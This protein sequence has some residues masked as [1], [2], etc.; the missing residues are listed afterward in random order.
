MELPCN[1][2][3]ENRA[4]TKRQIVKAEKSKP[5]S[6]LISTPKL[7]HCASLFID[8]EKEEL[9]DIKN[10]GKLAYDR[11]PQPKKYVLVPGITHYGIYREERERAVKLAI[12]WFDQY[13]KK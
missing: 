1:S 5:E 13:L 4:M 8:A 6:Y 3:T 7:T 9:F 12:E 10:H 11:A 2:T